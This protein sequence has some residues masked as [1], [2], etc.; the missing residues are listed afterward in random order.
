MSKHLERIMTNQNRVSNLQVVFA[1]IEKYSKRRTITQTEV[2][3]RFTTCLGNAITATSQ[4][5]IKYT[6][7][8]DINLQK[9][10][11][12]LPTGDGAAIVFSFDGLHNIHLFFAMHLLKEIHDLNEKTPCPKY[13]D[14]GWCN[15]HAN[16][17]V[18]IGVSEGR[19]VIYKDVNGN[20]NVAG[21][22]INF[23]SRVMGLADR[24][25]IMFTEEAYRQIIDMVDDPNLV[26]R[27]TEFKVSSP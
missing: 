16:L 14:Q 5:Y 10:I 21:G 4:E 1:D 23:A 25:Q 22:V 18:R 3:D 12:R 19:G 7:T 20:Y 27:F 11:I 15:C 13:D 9:D 26:D 6:Q 2:I 24:G 17:G 8:N